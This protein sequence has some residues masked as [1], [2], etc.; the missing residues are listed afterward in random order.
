M[1]FHYHVGNAERALMGFHYHVGNA[2]KVPM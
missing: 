2:E 1:R